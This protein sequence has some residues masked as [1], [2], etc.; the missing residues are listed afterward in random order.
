MTGVSILSNVTTGVRLALEI[1]WGADLTDLTA[2]SWTW[3]DV[4]GDVQLKS[5]VGVDIQ[6]GRPDESSQTQTAVL[7]ALLDNTAGA[8]SLGPQSSNYP[9]VT[10]NVPVRVRISTDSGSTWKV[11][12]QGN[13]VGFTPNWDSTG[14]WATVTLTASG[15]LRQLNQ[16][17]PRPISAMY[18]GTIADSTVKAYWPCEDGQGTTTVAAAI[19]GVDGV[20]D[21][22]DYSSGG[23]KPGTVGQAAAYDNIPA[24]NPI[25]TLSDGGLIDLVAT[26]AIGTSASSVTALF[27]NLNSVGVYDGTTLNKTTQKLQVGALMTV[28]TPNGG[29]L[30][31]WDVSVLTGGA[32]QVAGYASN[33]HSFGTNVFSQNI[34]YNWTPNTDYEIG[35]SFSQSG[36][37]TTWQLWITNLATGVN[38]FFSTTHANSGSSAC[39]VKEVEIGS[40]SDCG[41]LSVGHVAIRNTVLTPGADWLWAGGYVGDSPI[42]RLGRI[43]SVVGLPFSSYTSTATETSTNSA[44]SMGPQYS[45]TATNLLREAEATGFGVLCDGFNNGLSYFDRLL[46]HSQQPKMTL[47]ASTGVIVMPF[48]PVDD[49]QSTINDVQVSQRGGSN[50]TYVNAASIDAIGDYQSS[51]T[52]NQDSPTTTQLGYSAQKLVAIGIASTGVYRYPTWSFELEKQTA[53]IADWLTCF[54][55]CRFDV[56]NISSVRSQH[57]TG[58]IRNV[59]EGWHETISQFQWRVDANAT[60]YEPWKVIT[61]AAATGSTLDTNGRYE[62]DG[63]TVTTSVSA[64]ATSLSVTTASGPKWTTSSVTADDFPLTVAINGR[65][66][67]VTAISSTTSPQ[68]FT[69]AAVPVAIASGSAVTVYQNAVLG[70]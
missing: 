12:W 3:T 28:Y 35:L 9:H 37:T 54:P 50:V 56:T 29:S 8:Y 6:M 27:G 17:I 25:V 36:S 57:P 11:H 59:L 26:T 23:L 2:A 42:T 24:S 10:R 31:A 43:A 38:N 39:A 16:G 22:Y 52:V 65:P 53:R 4:T 45:D 67:T 60:T 13:A 34:S 44:D 19:G 70:M 64:G 46:R 62:S 47:D 40:Y 1:A 55:A 61:L 41:G 66:I 48:A 14:R 20:Y 63:S 18:Q 15:P 32:L 33:V 69:V 49:D 58:T 51:V 68:T 30:K 5:G 21:T 7:T